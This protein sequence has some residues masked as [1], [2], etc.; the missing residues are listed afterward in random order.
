MIQ[1]RQ[2]LKGLAAASAATAMA[3]GVPRWAR[4]AANT[5]AR[6]LIV[7]PAFGG[8]QIIDSVLPIRASEAG[9]QAN[10]IDC[11]PDNE[12][13]SLTGSPI[14]AADATMNHLVGQTIEQTFTVPLSPFIDKHKAQMMVTTLTGTSVNHAVAQHRSLTGGGAWGGRTLQEIVAMTYGKDYPLPNVNMSRMGYLQAGDDVTIPSR[15]RAEPILQPLVKPLSF[16]ASKGLRPGGAD[17]PAQGL[18]DK[19]RALRDD[20]LDPDSSFYQTFRLSER[21]KLWM[22]QRSIDATAIEKQNLIDKLFFVP[23]IADI[24]PLSQ[25]GLVPSEDALLLAET[26]PDMFADE[27][28]PF[29]Q[30]AAL[31]YLLIKNNASVTVTLSPTFAPVVGGPFGLK[32]VPLAFDGSHQDH[33]AAQAIMWFQMLSVVD[34]LIDL[35]KGAVFNPDTGETFWD[36]TMIHL[37]TD[38][39]R[40]KRRPADA[41]IWGTSHHLN[42]G[43]LTISPFVRGN[44]VLGGVDPQTALTY[45]FNTQTGAPDPSR[46]TTE[47]ES[48]SGLLQALGVDTTEANLPDVPC[49]RA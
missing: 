3:G 45:G 20:N 8:A 30:Q 17:I 5:D 40:D 25:Y 43:H 2:L 44:T 11:F 42:N 41:Q 36:R 18:I 9:S 23:E 22:R 48:F 38:F 29:E 19:A 27:P 24:L 1:R 49:M 31:A 34:R 35:L 21:I 4:A 10:V 26:F 46:N 15:V 16:S 6:F 32:T 37:A 13:V 12:V 7:V 28:D 39:G 14:R 33:R 47:A